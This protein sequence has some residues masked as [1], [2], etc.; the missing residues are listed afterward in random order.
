M[1]KKTNASSTYLF[2]EISLAVL[3]ITTGLAGITHYNSTGAEFMRSVNKA[4]GGS[5]DIVPIIMSIIELAAGVVI[6]LRLFGVVKGNVPKIAL[7]VIFIYWVVKILLN[8]I[9]ND[10]AEPDFIIWLGNIAPHLV[11]LAAIWIAYK[12]R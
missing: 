11:I 8:F 4:F 7:L 2:L 10:F 12:L 1:A 9:L 6:I 5:N 3:F